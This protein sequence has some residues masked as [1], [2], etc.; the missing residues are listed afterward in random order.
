VS[1]DAFCSDSATP[2]GED[3][4]KTTR[5]EAERHL[6]YAELAFVAAALNVSD[7]V[8]TGESGVMPADEAEA[9]A[10]L[11]SAAEGYRAASEAARR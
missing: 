9:L 1:A 3:R 10:R 2:R 7:V 5:R 11:R 6:H 8:L 4:R